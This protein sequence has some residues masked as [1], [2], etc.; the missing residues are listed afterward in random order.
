MAA[1]QHI[2][3]M[4]PAMVQPLETYIARFLEAGILLDSADAIKAP[5]KPQLS[6][7]VL[8]ISYDSR[9][10]KTDW[11]FV[12]KGEH[13]EAR[14]LENALQQGACAFVYESGAQHSVLDHEYCVH[15]IAVQFPKLLKVFQ[16]AG[17]I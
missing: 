14:F 5:T 10:I 3:A 7:P 1:E 12:C 9:E 16:D 8:G 13:Y 4:A 11:L 17:A 6:T 15:W 2:E